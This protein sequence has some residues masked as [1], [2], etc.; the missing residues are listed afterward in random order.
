M[1]LVNWFCGEDI[2]FPRRDVTTVSDDNAA[3]RRDTVRAS[4]KTILNVPP[5]PVLADSKPLT[6]PLTSGWFSFRLRE[7]AGVRIGG[8]IIGIGGSASDGGLFIG[9]DGNSNKLALYA[10]TSE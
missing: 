10:I 2:E 9:P 6:T 3:Y 5:T 8:A 4:L 1:S 7:D